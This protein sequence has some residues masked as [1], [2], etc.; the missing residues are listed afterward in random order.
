[1]SSAPTIEPSSALKRPTLFEGGLM[2]HGV[3]YDDLFRKGRFEIR[4][5]KALVLGGVAMYANFSLDSSAAALRPL[6]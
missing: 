4:S 1:L 2:S 3:D 5:F 6:S